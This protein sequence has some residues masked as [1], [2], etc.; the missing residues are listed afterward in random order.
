MAWGHD[1]NKTNPEIFCYLSITVAD[2]LFMN[3]KKDMRILKDAQCGIFSSKT[4]VKYPCYLEQIKFSLRLTLRK[5]FSLVS[6][7]GEG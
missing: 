3:L 2:H 5:E 1:P 4:E 7:E 6:A